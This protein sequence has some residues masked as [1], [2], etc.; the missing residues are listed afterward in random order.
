MAAFK[1][2]Q[3]GNIFFLQVQHRGVVS[4]GAIAPPN[5]S[6]SVNPISTGGGGTNYAHCTP[7]FSDLRGVWIYHLEWATYYQFQRDIF[8]QNRSIMYNFITTCKLFD[9]NILGFF[10]HFWNNLPIVRRRGHRRI[11]YTVAWKKK[12]APDLIIIWN[13]ACFCPASKDVS[14]ARFGQ[15][16]PDWRSFLNYF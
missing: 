16:M 11:H 15:F 3:V 12:N 8:L 1:S 13:P 2:D 10:K 4:G 7:G 5:V 9:T 6:R 14:G